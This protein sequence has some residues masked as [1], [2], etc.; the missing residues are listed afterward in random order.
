[1][2]RFGIVEAGACPADAN[3]DVVVD[4]MDLG[5]VLADWGL[6]CTGG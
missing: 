2:A 3:G 5:V 1:M 6:P 4:G